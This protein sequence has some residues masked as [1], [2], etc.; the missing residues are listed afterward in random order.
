LQRSPSDPDKD[1]V[2]LPR[3]DRERFGVTDAML[4]GDPRALVA[5]DSWKALM[6]YEVARSRAMMIDGSPLAT[7]LSGRIGLELRLIVQGGLRIL[8]KIEQVDYDV[9]FKRPTLGRRDAV[10]MAARAFRM[11]S[12]MR[13]DNIA[14]TRKLQSPDDA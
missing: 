2:Y 12:R 4:F 11:S 8:E 13:R 9:F 6:R 5:S 10:V 3:A 1:R 14:S 7:A